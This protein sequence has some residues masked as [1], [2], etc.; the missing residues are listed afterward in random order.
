MKFIKPFKGATGGN[1]YPQDFAVGDDCPD[2][3]AQAAQ[4]LGAVEATKQSR[5][6][7]AKQP[8]ESKQEPV[9]EPEQETGKK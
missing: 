4:E 1:P 6:E 9:N 8:K 5:Q 3:L 7:A 2:D